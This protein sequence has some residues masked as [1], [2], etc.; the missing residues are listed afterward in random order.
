ME[1]KYYTVGKYKI[2]LIC[3]QSYPCKHYIMDTTVTPEKTILQGAVDIY[4]MLEKEGLSHEHFDYCKEVIWKRDHPTDEEI[5]ERNRMDQI[6][7]E[8]FEEQAKRKEEVNAT[9]ASSYLDKLK[10]KHGSASIN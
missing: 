4:L 6:F 8:Y 7:L 3:L 9:K 5:D 10:R 2:S 1:D